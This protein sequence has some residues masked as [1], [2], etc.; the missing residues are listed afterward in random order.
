MP[1]FSLPTAALLATV[2]QALVAPGPSHAGSAAD[3]SRAP[4]P[5]AT[6][7]GRANQLHVTI[8]RVVGEAAEVSIDGV[9]N[10]PVWQQAALLTGFSQ[11]AP[12][13]GIAAADSTE[14]LLFYSP[15]ALYVG[16]R[17]FEPHGEVHATHADR[18]KITADDNVQLLLG[19]FNDQRQ[20]YVFAV[21][22]FGVQMDGTIIEAGAATGGW[23]PTLS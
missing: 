12:V 1:A 16:I 8:P 15:D 4:T 22:P 7:V 11:Y 3:T 17:A 6:F 23:T 2:F 20:A 9:L 21:N 5:N 13:D 10:E 14:V 19:T 18:D